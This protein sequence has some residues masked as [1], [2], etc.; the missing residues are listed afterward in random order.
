MTISVPFLFFFFVIFTFSNKTGRVRIRRL[1]AN[2]R[3]NIVAP[4]HAF[5]KHYPYKNVADSLKTVYNKSIDSNRKS[6]E[7]FMGVRDGTTT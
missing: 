3:A 4:R 2:T 6:K 7:L 1:G 5:V